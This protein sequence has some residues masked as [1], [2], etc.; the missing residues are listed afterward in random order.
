MHLLTVTAILLPAGNIADRFGRKNVH[1]FGILIF[2]IGTLLGVFANTFEIL[3]FSRI[4]MAIGSGMG[5]AVGGAIVSSL[6][7]DSER[8]KSLGMM[9]TSVGLGQ[10]VGPVVGGLLVYNFGWESVY[11][12]LLVPMI[13]AFILGYLLLKKDEIESV[14][15]DNQMFDYKGTLFGISFIITLIVGLKNLSFENIFSNYSIL[16]LIISIFFGLAFIFTELRANNP[17]LN[18]GLF[19]KKDFSVA[20]NTRFFAFMSMSTDMI[21]MPIFL[22]GL[23][24]INESNVGFML[25]FGAL[26][27]AISAPI[28]GRLSD[29]FG[30][31]KFII[32][33]LLLL[34]FAYAMISQFSVNSSKIFITS[35]LIIGGVG[36]GLWGSP[37][38]AITY[39]S[40]DKNQ[41]GFVS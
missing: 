1:I 22:T 17:L 5:Q 38:M 41:Y 14:D 30:R 3:I 13:L 19:K 25:I 40:L 28:G 21:M 12:F 39:S 34:I 26:A 10:T 31:E 6:F 2:I 15:S 23:L 4:I 27:F 18:F 37:N 9:S 29:Q 33:G 32:L 36:K 35:I 20:V 8:G 7:P 16:F 24:N 11:V